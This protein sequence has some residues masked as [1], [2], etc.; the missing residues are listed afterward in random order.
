MLEISSDEA[1]LEQLAARLRR[2][3]LDRNLTQDRLAHEAGVSTPTV[4]RLESGASIQFSTFV[5]VLRALDLLEGLDALVPVPAPRPME[6]L[7][8]EGR[9]RQRA[10][11][12]PDAEDDEPW[13]WDP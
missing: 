13:T 8:R 4:Q 6:L 2:H 12:T 3:R 9:R 10:T 1:I 11:S 7:E 5:R